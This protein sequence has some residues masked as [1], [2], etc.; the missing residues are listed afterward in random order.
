MLSIPNVP[1]GNFTVTAY[2]N[3]FV[4]EASGV[5]Q[6]S[7]LAQRYFIT[8]NAGITGSIQGHVLAGDG[9]TPV[10]ATQVE[11]LDVSTGI[12]L[13]LGGTDSNGFYRFNGI[14]AGPQGFKVRATSIL[15]PAIFAEQT[16]SFA[17]SGDM[18]TIDLTLP[19]SVIKGTV[20]YS[21]GTFVPFPT[22]VISQTDSFGNV[23][24]FLPATDANGGFEIV[25]LPLG[26]F[27]LSAQDSEYRNHH[28]IQRD[29]E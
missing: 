8:I 5:I 11:V 18:I 17:A 22:V 20:S 23:T 7:D 21:D 6:S 9:L 4:G 27:T 2:Q 15:N 12:Q 1:A 24:T 25:G 13:A 29:A 10:G 14:S 3:G 28:H 26:A 16:G 19:I